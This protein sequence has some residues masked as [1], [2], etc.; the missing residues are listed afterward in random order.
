MLGWVPCRVSVAPPTIP[1]PVVHARGGDAQCVMKY[2]TATHGVAK[3]RH[4][5]RSSLDGGGDFYTRRTKTD[6]MRDFKLNDADLNKL[7]CTYH[8]NPVNDSYAPMKLYL[9]TDLQARLRPHC[10]RARGPQF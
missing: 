4:K 7:R 2:G 8:T 3:P 9:I 5:A 6:A 10:L 1:R